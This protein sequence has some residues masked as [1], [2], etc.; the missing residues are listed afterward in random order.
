[1][2][3]H[4]DRSGEPGPRGELS[5]ER[6]D[7]LAEKARTFEAAS[8]FAEKERI[9]G[10]GR[11]RQFMFGSLDGLLVPLGVVSG[12]AGGTSNSKIVVVAGVAEAF[13]GALSMAAGEYLSGKA[14][15]Q[16]QAAA[17][18]SEEEEIVAIPDIE[19]LEIEL[20]FEREGLSA[21]DARLVADKVTTSHRSWVNTMVEKE[22]GLSAEPE[23]NAFKDSLSMGASYLLASL[24]PLGPYLFLSVRPAFVLSVALTIVALFVIGLVKGRLA[25]MSIWRSV[26]EVVVIGVASAAG[27]FLLGTLVPHLIGS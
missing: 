15:T 16:V 3:R 14:E 25:E 2:E 10:R 13:A 4:G 27:G 9:A 17:V 8:L 6:L 5:P 18:H 7:E 21:D 22:L 23:G 12:V 24:V 19:R 1:M 11:I 26:L 20:L